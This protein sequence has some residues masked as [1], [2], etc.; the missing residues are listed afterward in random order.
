MEA[1]RRR[2]RQVAPTPLP[3]LLTGDTG[4]GKE[5]VART[6]HELS[7]RTGPFLPVDCAALSASLV[8]TEL[9]GHERGAF[10]GAHQR[11]EGLVAAANGGT[12]FLDEVGELS[13]ETQTRLLRLLEEGTFRPVGTRTEQH[14]DLRIIAA[15]WRD[16]RQR[17]AEGSFRA[18]LYHRLA[19]VE[20]RL[21]S[22]R[23][24]LEDLD[25]LLDA[26]LAESA[27]ENRRPAPVLDPAVRVHLR[28]WPWPGN[29]REL[30]NV[31]AFVAAMTSG[32]QVRMTDLPPALL[33][34]P[35]E[36][37][38]TGPFV[39]PA[40]EIRIDLPYM[41]AR[42]QFLDDFQQRYVEAVLAA[43]EGNV[44]AAA[45]AAG[46]DRRSIQRI[47][48]RGRVAPALR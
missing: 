15:T 48:R 35:P 10:T 19:T 22:L 17:V 44:S 26:F 47:V 12:F 29:V 25:E 34:P 13:S 40:S 5:A 1:L 23:E 32:G 43:H 30:R 37:P 21:P 8:E 9:F 33:R 41:D 11:R 36:V 16:L 2:V 18:D 45:R 14:A 6:L 7:G 3:V 38:E 39:F 28:R 20:L 4:T 42:R 46:M 31:A 27:A 24:R